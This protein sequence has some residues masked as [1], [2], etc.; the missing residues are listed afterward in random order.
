MANEDGFKI[1]LRV[2]PEELQALEDYMAANDIDNRSDFIRD[3]IRDKIAGKAQTAEA[4]DNAVVVRLSPVVL[5]TIENMKA[6]GTIFDAESYIR[7]LIMT[8][9][10]PKEAVED[11]KAR[12]F[13]AAQQSSR[14]M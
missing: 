4:G 13:G 5:Q 2:S 8:D 9:I 6:D 14:I 1:T 12:A 11:S 10:I 3:M 7:Q